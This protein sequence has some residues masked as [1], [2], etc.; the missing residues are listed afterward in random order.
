MPASSESPSA[1]RHP[2]YK[3]RLHKKV[4]LEDSKLF[5]EKTK[6]KIKKKCKGLLSHSPDKVGE[7]L[8]FELKGYRKLKM[9]D[10]YRVVYRV[11]KKEH[12]VVILAVGIRRGG[13]VYKV[14]E[15]RLPAD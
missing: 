4:F 14:A 12:S 8:R 15:T 2:P 10:D 13:E 7:P 5:D 1:S 11:D 6:E 9:F 3:I